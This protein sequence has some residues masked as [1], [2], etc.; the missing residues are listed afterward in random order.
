LPVGLDLAASAPSTVAQN[1]IDSGGAFVAD[2]V[3]AVATGA[4][5][6]HLAGENQPGVDAT[7]ALPCGATRFVADPTSVLS[8]CYCY[9]SDPNCRSRDDPKCGAA[10]LVDDSTVVAD[11]PIDDAADP[12]CDALPRFAADHHSGGA[13]ARS[14]VAVPQLAA[15]A[16]RERA[17][18]P[19]FGADPHRVVFANHAAAADRR[20][21]AVPRPGAVL[22]I[23]GRLLVCV[24]P[25][26]RA[27]APGCGVP[28]RYCAFAPQLVCVADPEVAAVGPDYGA[29]PDAVA[30][31]FG[32]PL[33][34]ADLQL[35]V[36]VGPA[37]DV[38]CCGADLQLA[39]VAD[40]APA[41]RYCAAVLRPAG[42]DCHRCAADRSARGS[43]ISVLRD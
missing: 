42:A 11:P 37:L 32:D 9:A 20:Y 28:G 16:D 21:G 27:I 35:A 43:P 1:A 14:D 30:I 23:D 24:F 41:V 7:T 22:R 2:T 29:V 13:V 17:A 18:D 33:A 31:A 6:R 3:R 25:A 8:R 34:A 15:A 38:H 12:D 10:R 26:R 4:N 39:V 36:V 5:G 40:P 19:E